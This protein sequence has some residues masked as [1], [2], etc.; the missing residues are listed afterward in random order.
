MV[1]IKEIQKCVNYNTKIQ[2]YHY[3]IMHTKESIKSFMYFQR[4]K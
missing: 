4:M 2:I 1:N 3:I